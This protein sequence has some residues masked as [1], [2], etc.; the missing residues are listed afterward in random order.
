MLA[1]WKQW[2]DASKSCKSEGGSLA[3]IDSELSQALAEKAAGGKAVWIGGR[4]EEDA[5]EWTWSDNSTWGFTNWKTGWGY[6]YSDGCL[7]MI[8][9]G[10]WLDQNCATTGS[11]LCQG[12]MDVIHERNLTM[13]RLNKNQLKFLPLTITFKSHAQSNRID[14]PEEK[15]MKGFTLNWFVESSNGSVLTA[16]LPPNDKD[17]QQEVPTPKYVHPLLVGMIQL[18]RQLRLKNMTEDDMLGEVISKKVKKIEVLL[19]SGPGDT[20]CFARKVMPKKYEYIFSKMISS[21]IINDNGFPTEADMKTGYKLFQVMIYCP[22]A[23]VIK[24]FKFVNQM[25]SNESS[26]TIIQAVVNLFQPGVITQKES[27]HSANKFYNELASTLNL[28]YGDILLA[29]SSRDQLQDAL[30]NQ[31]PF[32]AK[33]T[34]LI[35]KCLQEFNCNGIQGI[36]K[37]LGIVI[38]SS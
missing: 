5:G 18:A 8:V 26:R 17:W 13:L 23:E 35:E 28:R 6:Q 38:L 4:R 20:M 30:M 24:L 31:L 25:L 2:P 32:F 15:K 29:T 14:K 10:K 7:K 11:F 3:A 37:K 34:E 1:E 21:E 27:F 36:I 22:Y 16:M 9:D 19:P 12:N 33:F